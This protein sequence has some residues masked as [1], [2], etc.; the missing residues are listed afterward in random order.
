MYPSPLL[1][2]DPLGEIDMTLVTKAIQGF[3]HLRNTNVITVA[4]SLLAAQLLRGGNSAHSI[5]EIP[6]QC[7]ESNTCIVP[8]KFEWDADIRNVA[9]IISD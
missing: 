5:F 4:T 6:I 2:I 8:A 1:V 7:C 3:L 9:L